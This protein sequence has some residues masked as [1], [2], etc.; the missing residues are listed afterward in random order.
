MKQIKHKDMTIVDGW[1]HFP[2]GGMVRVVIVF[3]GNGKVKGSVT[4]VDGE[5]LVDIDSD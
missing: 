4:T 3:H 5:L 2:D 1:S